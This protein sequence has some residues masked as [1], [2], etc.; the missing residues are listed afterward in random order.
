M[1]KQM[2]RHRYLL[3]HETPPLTATI[4]RRLSPPMSSLPQL[5]QGSKAIPEGFPG[6]SKRDYFSAVFSTA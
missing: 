2:F 1:E 3:L 5:L 4:E 6:E